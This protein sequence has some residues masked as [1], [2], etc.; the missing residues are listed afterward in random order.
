[1]RETLLNLW[2]SGQVAIT[3][4]KQMAP[5]K[6]IMDEPLFETWGSKQGSPGRLA[7]N[8][9]VSPVG[10]T[11]VGETEVVLHSESVHNLE[12]C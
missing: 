2:G 1:M 5:S 9:V 7:V 8:F 11:A 12:Q 3:V 4:P 6:Q 10:E